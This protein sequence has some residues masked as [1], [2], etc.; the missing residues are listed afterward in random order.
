LDVLKKCRQSGILLAFSTA[1]PKT[2]TQPFVDIVRPDVSISD[3]G[4]LA[5]MGDDVIYRA[6]LP[7]AAVAEILQILQGDSQ[8]GYITASTDDGLLVN[9]H[10]DPDDEGWVD[11]KPIHA[12]FSTIADYDLFKISAEI[13]DARVLDD[14]AALPGITY[15]PY[16]GENWGTITNAGITKWQTIQKVAAHLNIDTEHIVAFGDDFGDVEMLKNCGIGVAVANAIPEVKAVADF[17]CESNDEDGVAR[18]L[19][20]NLWPSK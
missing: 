2:A 15:I 17:V 10:V 3:S 13:F 6:A 1:R 11:W 18:W 12:D 19:E 7:K 20:E 9:Y 14:L 4:A 5:K 8:V 16:S